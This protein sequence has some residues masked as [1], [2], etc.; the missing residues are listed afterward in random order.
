MNA[1]GLRTG[2]RLIAAGYIG[3]VTAA[4][5]AYEIAGRPESAEPAMTLAAWPGS[6]LLLLFVLYPLALLLGDDPATEEAGFSLLNPLLQGAGALVN[7]LALWA[8][9]AFARH[10]AAEW[11]RSRSS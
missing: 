1:L 10:F 7:V 6:I 5:L 2:P 3:L 9:I 4:A 11:S 8:V